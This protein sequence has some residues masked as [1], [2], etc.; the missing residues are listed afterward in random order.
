MTPE[1]IAEI[2][3]VITSDEAV[4]AFGEAWGQAASRLDQGA[5]YKPG[6]RRRAGLRAVA[7]LLLPQVK[8]AECQV[9]EPYWSVCRQTEPGS[10]F[11]CENPEPEHVVHWVSKHTRNHAQAGS[12]YPCSDI[13]PLYR[14]GGDG[15]I[16]Y[17]YS[18]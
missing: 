7:D 3:K 6:D 11:A 8:P 15:T 5:A 9:R 12:R 4:R 16:H 14:P 2:Q 10:R 17:W 13:E 18:R 1:E